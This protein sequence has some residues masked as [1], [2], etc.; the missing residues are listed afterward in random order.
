MG[1]AVCSFNPVYGQGM[2]VAAIEAN[3]LREMI[4]DVNES[5]DL[6]SRFAR[7]WFRRIA[8]VI[9]VAWNG[10]C[11][12][13]LRFPQL[14]ERRPFSL[15]PVQWYMERVHRATHYSPAVTTQFYR[16]MNF[17]DA[18]TTLFRPHL[19]RKVLLGRTAG[20]STRRPEPRAS[21]SGLRPRQGAP[22]GL[23]G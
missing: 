8:S 12:E 10:V 11:I 6:G 16:V 9:D 14:A 3:M 13:D 23:S 18:P 5:S 21:A 15:R 17:L 19:M 22:L 20:S 2:T 1:D 4:A 7:A